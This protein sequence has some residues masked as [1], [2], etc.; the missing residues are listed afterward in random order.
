MNPVK[1]LVTNSVLKP[2]M[3]WESHLLTTSG[4][5]LLKSSLKI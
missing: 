4:L 1:T 2:V 3:N 5:V